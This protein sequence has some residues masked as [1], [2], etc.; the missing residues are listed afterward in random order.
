[1]LS[2]VQRSTL[3]QLI[4]E[5]IDKRRG[6]S[7]RLAGVYGSTRRGDTEPW[8]AVELLLVVR[9]RRT[10][11]VPSFL[12]HNVPVVITRI[13]EQELLAQLEVPGRR[14]SYWMGVLDELLPLAG[15]KRLRDKWS[16]RGRLVDEGRFNDLLT[17]ILPELV[18][19]AY[20]GVLESKDETDCD[21]FCY[22]VR[23]MLEE[24]REVL[25]LLNRS[26]TRKPGLAG[27]REAGN[28]AKIP[29]D[30]DDL[31][32]E[33]WCGNDPRRGAATAQKLYR[34]YQALLRSA[35]LTPVNYSAMTELEGRL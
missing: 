1:M 13:D 6:D 19:E 7:L 33:L 8:N 12:Y 35:G 20:G 10:V 32:V 3:A 30:Y 31:V 26:W 2:K 16:A 17:D 5:K 25:C 9:H 4:V 22:C 11:K 14:W 23:R 15:D 18:Y 28:F 34:G 21:Q 24:L 29:K 27:I